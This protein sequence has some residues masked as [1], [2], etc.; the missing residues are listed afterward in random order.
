MISMRVGVGQPPGDPVRLGD[1]AESGTRLLQR[2]VRIR[3]IEVHPHE[4]AVLQPVVELLALQDVGRVA[5]QKGGHGVDE[6]GLV[7]AR[8]VRTNSRPGCG[9][10]DMT[11]SLYSA[12]PSGPTIRS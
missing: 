12:W 7:R 11:S 10:G 8:K 9:R 4:E 6:T 1:R 5:H 3:D 2:D